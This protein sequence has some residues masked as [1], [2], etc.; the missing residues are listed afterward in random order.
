MWQPVELTVAQ[1]HDLIDL[2]TAMFADVYVHYTK[3]ALYGYDPLRALMACAARSRT[4]TRR[5]SCAS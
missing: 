3:R 2:W 4:S 5:A 1:R